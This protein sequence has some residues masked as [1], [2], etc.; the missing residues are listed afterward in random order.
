M[1]RGLNHALCTA[2]HCAQDLR[3]KDKLQQLS[4]GRAASH[5][6]ARRHVT[7]EVALWKLVDESR[8]LTSSYTYTPKFIRSNRNTQ[9]VSL[10]ET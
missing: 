1:E 9:H 4:A 10:M 2:V 6:Q 8:H 5:L 3:S 7:A